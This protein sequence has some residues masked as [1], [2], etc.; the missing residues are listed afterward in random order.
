LDRERAQNSANLRAERLLRKTNSAKSPL[1]SCSAREL[2]TEHF[3]GKV[4]DNQAKPSSNEIVGSCAIC[5]NDSKLGLKSSE[6]ETT[7]ICK[8]GKSLS[9]YLPEPLFTNN[10]F[11]KKRGGFLFAIY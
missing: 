10:A 8:H 3:E 6:K 7:S 1:R 11:H 4:P 2:T 9:P 5:V